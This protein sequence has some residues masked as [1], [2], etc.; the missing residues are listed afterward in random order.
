VPHNKGTGSVPQAF[1]KLP[2]GTHA[3]IKAW[4]SRLGIVNKANNLILEK[5]II[6]RNPKKD[7]AIITGKYIARIIVGNKCYHAL[8]HILKKR[9]ITHS[10]R[11]G[12]Y[13]TVIGPIATNGGESWNL[14]NKMDRALT[15]GNENLVKN[16]WDKI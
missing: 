16:M 15:V 12:L 1:N 7:A 9:H 6:L 8:D 10:L 4:S 11:V 13:E 2:R 3:K 14:T 5:E